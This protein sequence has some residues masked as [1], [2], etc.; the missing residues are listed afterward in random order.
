M[1]HLWAILLIVLNTAWLALVV[2]GL[3]GNWLMAVS[4]VLL[5]WWGPGRAAGSPPMFSTGVLIAIAGL[6]LAGEAC[7]FGAGLAGAKQAGGTRR[8]ALGALIGALAGGIVGTFFIPLLGS[9]VGACVGAA[10]GAWALELTGGRSQ[11]A[12][13]KSG[14]GAGVGRLAGTLAKLGAGI[15][16]WLIVAVAA[17]WP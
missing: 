8:G 13:L 4:A 1:T 15:V 10:L 16:I 14:V 3:P 5:N 12:S 2:I 6:A 9:L 17:F 11:R 7:E